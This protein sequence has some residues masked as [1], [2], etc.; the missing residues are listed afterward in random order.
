M[1]SGAYPLLLYNVKQGRLCHI[2]SPQY[3]CHGNCLIG[4]EKT[5]AYHS[6]PASCADDSYPVN[7]YFYHGTIGFYSFYEE[8]AGTY[9][10]KDRTI[11]GIIDELGTDDINGWL[12]AQDPGSYGYR[13][14]GWYATVGSVWVI[15]RAF[16]I[17]RSYVACKRYGHKCDQLGEDLDRKTIM[18]FVHENMRLPAHGTTNYHRVVLLYL[19]VEGIMSDLFLLVATEGIY[20]WV[21]YIS[22]GYNL[23]GV[24]L[25]C[26]EIVENMGWLTETT[27]LAV[28]RL[29]F[30]YESSLV[31]ELLSAIGQSHFLTGLSHSD[32]KN[33]GSAVSY[34]VWGLVGHASIVLTLIGSIMFV[35]VVRAVTYMRWKHGVWWSIFTAP[36][37][38]DTT[39]GMLNKMK[40]LRGYEWK[41]GNS[42]TLLPR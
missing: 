35:R 5:T 37:C 27:R 8:V 15:Y 17:R 32:L 34:Y 16:V 1:E 25:L 20:S 31:G 12:L 40:M 33:S 23:S 29:L 24:V 26:F 28:K 21:Q 42:T 6:V 39:L 11:Y 18:V 9:C 3:N 38:V 10:T 36:C 41:G 19:L 4:A 7:L 22:F 13:W 30:S 2:V 14:S